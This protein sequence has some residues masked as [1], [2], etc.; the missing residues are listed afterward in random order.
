MAT[1]PTPPPSPPGPVPNPF[2]PP[3]VVNISS[4]PEDRTWGM[5]CHLGGIL[6]FLIPLVLWL[7]KR[8]DSRFVDDQGKEALNF[9]LSLLIFDVIG[10]ATLIIFI[11]VII[12]LA[13]RVIGALFAVQGAMAANKG[14]VY[15]YPYSYRFIK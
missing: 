5:I 14:E 12:L 2:Q 7:T 11:G 4:D 9:Q 13:S 6:G 10:V 1:N 3:P 8:Q 15:R